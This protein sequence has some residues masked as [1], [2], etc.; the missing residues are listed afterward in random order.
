MT[1]ESHTPCQAQN[2]KR[3]ANEHLFIPGRSSGGMVPRS[4]LL[5]GGRRG[6]REIAGQAQDHH[7]PPHQDVRPQ[8]SAG[9]PLLD[10]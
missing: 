8:E 9:R 2:N 3:K 10:L 5:C 7:L 1:N 4:R 6:V